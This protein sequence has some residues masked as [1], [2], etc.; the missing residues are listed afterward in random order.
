MSKK[1]LKLI[2]AVLGLTMIVSI[3]AI[4]CAPQQRPNPDRY[5]MDNND[6]NDMA[7]G[8]DTRYSDRYTGRLPL[9]GPNTPNTDRLYGYTGR[10]MN[11]RNLGYDNLPEI[12]GN[13]TGMD[14]NNL[15]NN[16]MN[17]AQRN[18]IEDQVED[19]AD[20]KDATIVTNED[21][22]YVGIDTPDGKNVENVAAL[23]TNIANK[24]RKINP[25]IKRVYVTTD[26]NRVSRL[27]N[28]AR[29]ID[30]GKPVRN[31]LN[32]LEDLFE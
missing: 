18:R 26:K 14:R 28:Y 32:D 5:D 8:Y 19:L 10:D 15:G 11:N 7:R 16:A 2:T 31:F 4:G 22:C 24:V 23:R 13:R 1:N 6:T 25:D 12:G 3:F 29:D 9:Y 21:T 20:V 17:M 30:L 27:R